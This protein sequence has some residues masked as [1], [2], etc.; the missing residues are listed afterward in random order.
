MDLVETV[1][2]LV[3]AAGAGGQISVDIFKE[4]TPPDLRS[5][6]IER[7]IDILNE[8]GVWIVEE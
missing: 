3:L 8:Q 4:L 6:D 2:K 1:R 7:L 5:E